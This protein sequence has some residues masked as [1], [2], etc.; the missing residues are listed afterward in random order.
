MEG[1]FRL[2]T[3]PNTPKLNAMVSAKA[4]AGLW[5]LAHEIVESNDNIGSKNNFF[6]KLKRISFDTLSGGKGIE[7]KPSGSDISHW[8]IF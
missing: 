6:P 4:R 8:S 5:Q 2:A 1:V 7:G 3:L